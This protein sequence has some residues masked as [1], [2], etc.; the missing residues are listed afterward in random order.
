MSCRVDIWKISQGQFDQVSSQRTLWLMRWKGQVQSGLWVLWE[1]DLHQVWL[2]KSFQLRWSELMFRL[3]QQQDNIWGHFHQE[4]EEMEVKEL[5]AIQHAIL[6]LH[7]SFLILR[8]LQIEFPSNCHDARS[9]RFWL[10]LLYHE[11]SFLYL[12]SNEWPLKDQSLE[13]ASDEGHSFIPVQ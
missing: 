11:W 12:A 7:R 8:Y 5:H 9:L 10:L 13:E 1:I 4:E 6:T 2:S 3:N